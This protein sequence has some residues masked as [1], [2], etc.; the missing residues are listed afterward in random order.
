MKHIIYIFL[1]ILTGSILS[2]KAQ[3]LA[4]SNA[5]SVAAPFIT[6][7]IDPRGM[8]MG[9]TASSEA[10]G[11]QSVIWNPAGLAGKGHSFFISHSNW[12]A[13]I[14]V[15]QV[16]LGFSIPSVGTVGAYLTS[17]NYGDMKVRTVTERD[18][19]GE[20]FSSTDFS[21]GLYF[22][23]DLTDRLKLGVGVKYIQQKIW[24][25]SSNSV[26]FDIGTIF[27]MPFLGIDFGASISNFGGDMRLAGRDTRVQYDI[28]PILAGNNE[29]VPAN[30]ELA[31]WPLPLML[32]TGIQRSF[33]MDDQN[34]ILLAVD[35]LYPQDNYK[36][37]NFG[38]E[39][40]FK[41]LFSLRTGYRGLFLEDNQGGL[42]AGAGF[43]YRDNNLRWSLD[44]GYMD[45]GILNQVYIFGLSLRWN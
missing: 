21:L 39:Y 40:N 38:M 44:L 36:S 17:V 22:A 24:H 11:I 4:I 15:D 27:K 7:S 34:Q 14:S 13:D 41:K 31:S 18:G 42:S 20:N 8:G 16:G 33:S 30:L 28:D 32:R 1:L 19:T 35:A 37:L 3:G 43:N 6:L 26:A 2:L 9:G 5:G 25:T 45:F 23:R 12:L 10:N 29:K